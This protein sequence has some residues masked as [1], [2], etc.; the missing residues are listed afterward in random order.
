[1]SVADAKKRDYSSVVVVVSSKQDL[2]HGQPNYLTKDG[3]EMVLVNTVMVQGTSTSEYDL[4][5]DHFDSEYHIYKTLQQLTIETDDIQSAPSALLKFQSLK[6]LTISGSR[7]WSLHMNETPK[8]L[9]ELDLTSHSNLSSSVCLHA[10]DHHALELLRLDY[11]AF[12]FQLIDAISIADE[13]ETRMEEGLKTVGPIS[14]L[15]K[16]SRVEIVSGVGYGENELVADWQSRL[17]NHVLFRNVKDRI[18]SVHFQSDDST[19]VVILLS[20]QALKK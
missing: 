8:S 4:L 9:V 7:F 13:D 10:D 3:T 11:N 2:K 12:F 16:L 15:R 1:M 14:D 5:F 18:H 19:F 17:I 20:R 6:R